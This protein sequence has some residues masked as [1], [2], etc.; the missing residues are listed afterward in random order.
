MPL[1]NEKQPAEAGDKERVKKGEKKKVEG[2][3]RVLVIEEEQRERG[4]PSCSSQ[5]GEEPVAD[6]RFILTCWFDLVISFIILMF[7]VQFYTRFQACTQFFTRRANG[8]H[9]KMEYARAFLQKEVESE[10][11]YPFQILTEEDSFLF[12]FKMDAGTAV[13]V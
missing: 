6:N 13:L 5:R 4:Q 9:T 3:Q 1:E 8:R 2:G 10:F 11:P 7:L 12:C